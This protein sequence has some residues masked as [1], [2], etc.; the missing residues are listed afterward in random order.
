MRELFCGQWIEV[1]KKVYWQFMLSEFQYLFF[2]VISGMSNESETGI[3]WSSRTEPNWFGLWNVQT[4]MF[5]LV[6]KMP[7]SDQTKMLTSLKFTIRWRKD[8][9]DCQLT[10]NSI[11]FFFDLVKGWP[12]RRHLRIHKKLLFCGLMS[13][14]ES[15][16]IV[17]K[18]FMWGIAKNLFMKILIQ[19]CGD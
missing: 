13:R 1:R 5:G 18:N 15:W 8:K 11:N 3:N 16:L 4:E 19:P 12:P 17:K 2:L 9:E 10:R 7:K 14:I 6:W